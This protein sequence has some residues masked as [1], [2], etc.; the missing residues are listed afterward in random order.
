MAKLKT[1]LPNKTEEKLG[2][3]VNFSTRW[4]S[5]RQSCARLKAEMAGDQD[6]PECTCGYAQAVE[7]LQTKIRKI[8]A[9]RPKV[10]I[11]NG[12]P[13]YNKQ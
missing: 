13:N 5:H 12:R 6:L 7:E 2:L 11:N 8:D 4:C 9:P 10:D 3:Y 1:G